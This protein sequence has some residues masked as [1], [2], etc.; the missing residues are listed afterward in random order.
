MVH[1]RSRDAPG[2]TGSEA[3]APKAADMIMRHLRLCALLL[4]G[5]IGIANSRAV[6]VLPLLKTR[7]E[8]FENVTLVSRTATHLFVHHSRGV[9]NIKIAEVNAEA[10]LGLGLEL[11]AGPSQGAKTRSAGA[12][13][14]FLP[15]AAEKVKTALALPETWKQHMPAQFQLPPLNRTVLLSILGG[16]LGLFL[17]FSYCAALICKKAG[18]EPGALVWLP[19]FNLFPMLRAAGMSGW[20]FLAFMVP[21]FNLV[22]QVTWS[23]KISAA[24]GK[25][26]F[27]ALLLLLPVTGIFAFMYLAFSGGGHSK[28]C[29]SSRPIQLEPLPA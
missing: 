15:D 16:M 1:A 18:T 11:Q 5:G 9:A 14:T 27:T 29:D 6:D 26:V 3:N 4:T 17:F 28:S 21:V 19:V 25:G 2:F 7:T 12:G 22:A 23:L 13:R 20:W 10:L 24:R 8:T